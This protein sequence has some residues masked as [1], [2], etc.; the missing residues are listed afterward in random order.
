M[1]GTN[2]SGAQ[3]PC[4]SLLADWGTCPHD[5]LR[6]FPNG[7]PFLLRLHTGAVHVCEL[8]GNM[9]SDHSWKARRLT[10]GKIIRL[11]NL[12]RAEFIVLTAN[13]GAVRPAVAGMH[14]P[15]VGDSG[16]EA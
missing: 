15:L 16:G 10:D 5:R 9:E 14:Q 13:A 8:C 12:Q 1:S 4:I 2:A 7:T 6:K 3:V 11:E